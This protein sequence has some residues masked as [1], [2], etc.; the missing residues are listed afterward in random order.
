MNFDTHV[1]SSRCATS[2]E[3]AVKPASSRSQSAEIFVVG[4]NYKAPDFIDSRMLD[5][6]HAFQQDFE[7]EGGQKG[8]SIFHK[9]YEQHNKRHRQGYA[10]DLGMSLSRVTK[11]RKRNRLLRRTGKL[12]PTWSKLLLWELVEVSKHIV[13]FLRPASFN[14]A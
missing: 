5:P 11:V 13:F 7:M 14:I 4:R 10:D 3:Q 1:I 9:K 6:K 8:L 12:T 2:P